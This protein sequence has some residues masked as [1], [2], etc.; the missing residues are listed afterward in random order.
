MVKLTA[1]CPKPTYVKAWNNVTVT[2]VTP[3]SDC[4]VDGWDC[5][6]E[7][8]WK[9]DSTDEKVKACSGDSTPWYLN[10][11]LQE[12]TGIIIDEVWCDWSNSKLRISID[13]DI[14]PECPDVPDLV[15]NNQSSIIQ[16]SQ[17]WTHRHVLTITDKT[18]P[19]YD[20]IVCVGFNDSIDSTVNM[21]DT[22]V[23]DNPTFIWSW[24]TYW[25]WNWQI[26]T[27]NGNLATSKW[28]R[29]QQQWYYRLF[30]Q[31]TVWNN[32]WNT[33]YIN[34]WRWLLLVDSPQRAWL[35]QKAF[36]L[37]TAKHWSYARHVF[38]T[39]WKWITID[40]DGKFA[41]TRATVTTDWEWWTYEV[42]FDNWSWQPIWGHD[43]PWMTFNM[44]C[45]VDLWEW[46]EITL[47]YR[48]QSDMEDAK[49]KSVSYKF[50]WVWDPTTE[51]HS[52]F[53][54]TCLWVQMISPT[55][56][57]KDASSWTEVWE[58]IWH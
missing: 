5:W 45:Y 16:T 23:A 30:G 2:E 34:L 21:R 52:L 1:E 33:R 35:S 50:V 48:C 7:W 49:W 42:V 22:W 46:D 8:W 53:W 32:T 17:S 4:Y 13:E 36:Y 29:I 15:V 43:W 24:W 10:Q 25:K 3:P 18:K 6:I 57:Q 19:L 31:L 38:P 47:W 44:D 40:A 26:Y 11:K 28:I 14:L 58:W 41:V 51:Y 56:F 9:I 20:N 12:G 55:L 37:S 27:G 39:G 54:W